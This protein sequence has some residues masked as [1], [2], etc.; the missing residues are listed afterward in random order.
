MR[1][2]GHGGD[3]HAVFVLQGFERAERIALASPASR[4]FGA[5][6]QIIDIRQHLV[7]AGVDGIDIHSH[8]DAVG[9][10]NA[11]GVSDGGGIVPIDVQQS[12]ICDLFR[13]DL[14]GV[15]AQAFVTPPEDRAFAG[16]LIDHDVRRLIGAVGPKLHVLDIERGGAQAFELDAAALVIAHRADV[17]GA[18]A[19]ARARHH[20]ASHL[21]AWAQDLSTK[22]RLAGVCREVRN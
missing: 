1:A 22:R 13:G 11:R 4:K 10:G 19:K 20:G 6:D 15:D 2:N 17:L 16:G 8:R 12:R 7:E 18:Q 21:P 14:F 5:G 3:A 9:A